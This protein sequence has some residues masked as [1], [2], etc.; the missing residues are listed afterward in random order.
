MVQYLSETD[1]EMGMRSLKIGKSS[2]ELGD[3][4][5]RAFCSHEGVGERNLIGSGG[6]GRVYRGVVSST[7]LEVAIKRVAHDS[8]QGMKEFVA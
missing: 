2:M 4:I 5:F 3:Q 7:G 8:R 6:F 1:L